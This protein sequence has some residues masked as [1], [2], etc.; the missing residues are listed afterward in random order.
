MNQGGLPPW[1]NSGVGGTLPPHTKKNPKNLKA[2]FDDSEEPEDQKGDEGQ[3]AGR[4]D[5]LEEK[6][7]IAR[8]VA[9]AGMFVVLNGDGLLWD[10]GE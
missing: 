6:S 1:F 2:D 5:E 10:G 7:D 9:H 8:P 4:T 3:G